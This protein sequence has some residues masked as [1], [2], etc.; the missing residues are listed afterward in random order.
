M[1]MR[2]GSV[3]LA[4]RRRG[5]GANERAWRHLLLLCRRGNRHLRRFGGVMGCSL[6]TGRRIARGEYHMMG[7]QADTDN[8]SDVAANQTRPRKFPEFASIIATHPRFPQ[9]PAKHAQAPS[10]VAPGRSL[11]TVW[12]R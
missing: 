9:D 3:E 4:A 12:R 6:A 1:A 2:Y 10:D 8:V 11:R 5:G 7:H